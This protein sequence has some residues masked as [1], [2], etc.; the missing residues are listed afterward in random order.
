MIIVSLVWV[1]IIWCFYWEISS[2]LRF[3]SYN[4]HSY[5]NADEM[6]EFLFKNRL[7]EWFVTIQE[8]MQKE[9]D[10][11][12]SESNHSVQELLSYCQEA[13]QSILCTSTTLRAPFTLPIVHHTKIFA[14]LHTFDNIVRIYMKNLNPNWAALSPPTPVKG[15]NG[16]TPSSVVANFFNDAQ[17]LTTC[18]D[19]SQTGNARKSTVTCFTSGFELQMSPK[20]WTRRYIGGSFDEYTSWFYWNIHKWVMLVFKRD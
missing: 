16:E 18:Q 5:T 19:N 2:T 9:I 15:P 11:I 8:S 10:N 12:H 13:M 7:Q 3:M 1:V 20:S 6:E 14:Q 4:L 17:P